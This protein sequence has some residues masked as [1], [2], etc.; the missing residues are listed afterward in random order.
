MYNTYLSYQQIKDYISYLQ[1]N[2]M[3]IYNEKTSHYKIAENGI[4]FLRI[5]QQMN[6][7]F[8]KKYDYKVPMNLGLNS[9][10]N[11]WCQ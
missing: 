6:E 10:W 1:E 2:K 9:W 5:Y 8:S 3:L 4:M 11:V 7:L